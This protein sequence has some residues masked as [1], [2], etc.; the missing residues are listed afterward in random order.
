[1]TSPIHFETYG[2]G[3]REIVVLNGL[4]QSTANWRGIARQNPKFRW[5]LFDARGHGK[6]PISRGPYRLDDHVDDL[7][8]VLNQTGAGK[9]VLMGFSHGARVVLRAAAER[10]ERFAAAILISCGS[11]TTVRRNAYT[12]SWEQCLKLGGV[13]GLAWASLPAIVG[14]KVLANFADL[15]ILVKGTAARNHKE[16][17]LAVFEGMKTYPPPR[18]DAVRVRAPSLVMRGAEDPLVLAE[19]VDDLCAW[20]A[21]ARAAVFEECGHTLPLEEPQRFIDAVSRFIDG[22]GQL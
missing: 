5:I 7:C 6:S 14:P 13:E 11:A 15:E 8:R 20:I 10:P 4:S 19:D 18:E 12:A 21:G 3:P 2:E 1:M 16:G 17:L 9:P 22:L